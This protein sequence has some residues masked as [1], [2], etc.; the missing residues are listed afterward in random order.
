MTDP[1]PPTDMRRTL[2]GL[3]LRLLVWLAR[4]HRPETPADRGGS[5]PPGTTC[6]WCHEYWPCTTRR[7]TDERVER[8]AR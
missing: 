5:G 7:E 4:N 6:A 2:A 3:T 8:F 1:T